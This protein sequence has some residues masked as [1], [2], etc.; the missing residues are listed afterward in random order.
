MNP[1]RS[2]DLVCIFE[3]RYVVDA[4]KDV[5]FQRRVLGRD[6]VHFLHSCQSL[7]APEDK[8]THC[9]DE[10]NDGEAHFRQWGALS[11]KT[12]SSGQI[13]LKVTAHF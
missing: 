7:D 4:P 2:K 5:S 10:L 6:R 9:E 8:Q 1:L 13:S 3:L 11:V 12:V